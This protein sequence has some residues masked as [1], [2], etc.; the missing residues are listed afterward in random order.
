MSTYSYFGAP[1]FA[2]LGHNSMFEKGCHESGSP[3]D[4]PQ[5]QCA[6]TGYW[7][8]VA[9]EP[10]DFAEAVAAEAVA[11]GDGSAAV[12]AAIAETVAT[13]D[14]AALAA[15]GTE[16]DSASAQFAFAATAA[17]LAN[18]AA[19]IEGVRSPA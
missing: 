2:Q 8:T 6:Y 16:S 18:F 10:V 13:T 15:A 4:G 14:A 11:A 1:T 7:S 19:H 17:G 5:A 12:V 9:D 3:L